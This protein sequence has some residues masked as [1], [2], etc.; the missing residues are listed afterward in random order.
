M[1]IER[2]DGIQLFEI[3]FIWAFGL[4]TQTGLISA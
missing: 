2:T 1:I 4:Y 3:L